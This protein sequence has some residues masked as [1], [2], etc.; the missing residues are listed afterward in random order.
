VE[1]GR[2]IEDG[3]Y[4]EEGVFILVDS[5]TETHC[6]THVLELSSRFK[7]GNVISIS[8]GEEHKNIQTCSD[9]WGDLSKAGADRKSLLVNL[10]GGMI[11]D[12][13]GFVASTYMRG[14][15]FINLPT[16]L[17]AQ[18]DASIGGKVGV[19]LHNLKNQVG[20]FN[21]PNAVFIYPEFLKTLDKRQLLSG[22]AEVLKH[23][24]IAD[25][26]Y[27]ELAKSGT[28]S[29]D[30]EAIISKSIEIKNKI[31]Q[32]DPL[33]SGPRKMLNF[34]H[35]IGHAIETCSLNNK[36]SLL[37]GEAV[38]I[39]M[40]CE[41]YLSNKLTGLSSKS[42]E[43]ITSSMLKLYKPFDLEETSYA[44]LLELMR[45]D[46]KNKGGKMNFTLLRRIGD[47]VIDQLCNDDLITES[48][49]YYNEQI[50][51]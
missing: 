45:H 44:N 46:K 12:L 39:G 15:D 28:E 34:G 24:L 48:L 5:Q 6:L 31:V 50:K 20:L 8:N 25:A 47:A 21:N 11:T 42:L 22:M 14:I 36:R 18:V 10:G 30:W 1:L 38:A 40:I 43:D 23:G 32:Q 26:N 2:F 4:P 41:S 17:L 29:L 51:L 3:K 7:S 19:D 37:H 49:I 9:V 27:W 35:T 13:G 33:E 16:T